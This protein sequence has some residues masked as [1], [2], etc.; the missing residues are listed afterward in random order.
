MYYANTAFKQWVYAKSKNR[1]RALWQHLNACVGRK[2]RKN[3][4]A[5]RL[6]IVVKPIQEITN[7]AGSLCEYFS[8]IGPNTMESIVPDADTFGERTALLPSLTA[9]SNHSVQTVSNQVKKKDEN[10]H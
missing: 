3:A 4:T 10:R 6:I 1:L 5:I 2:A 9:F 8:K 7:A